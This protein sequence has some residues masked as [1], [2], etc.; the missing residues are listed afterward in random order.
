MFSRKSQTG[1]FQQSNPGFQCQLCTYTTSK[2]RNLTVHNKCHKEQQYECSACNKKFFW[3]SHLRRHIRIHKLDDLKEPLPILEFKCSHCSFVTTSKGSLTRH[4][5]IH[6]LH[7]EPQQ[8]S[9]LFKC[10]ECDFI[11]CYKGNLKKHLFA[12][13][14]HIGHVL[15]KF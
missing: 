14:V 6:R 12:T 8:R 15:R 4:L 7:E 10:T 2:K 5:L 3:D 1:D 13:N 11:T 9:K